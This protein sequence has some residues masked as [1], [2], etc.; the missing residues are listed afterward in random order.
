MASWRVTVA[1]G[2]AIAW[3]SADTVRASALLSAF[4]TLLRIIS[5]GLRSGEQTGRKD[6]NHEN[7]A[8]ATFSWSEEASGT[9]LGLRKLGRLP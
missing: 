6:T 5:M 7:V 3:V 2:D 4:L 9:G 1:K 8:G